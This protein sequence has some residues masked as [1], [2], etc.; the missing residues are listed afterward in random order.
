MAYV[1][2]GLSAVGSEIDID[3][4]GRVSRAR[5]APMPFYKRTRH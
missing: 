1:P 5:V 2:I 4:R 3:I